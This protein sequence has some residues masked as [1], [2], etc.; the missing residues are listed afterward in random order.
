MHIDL[1]LGTNCMLNMACESTMDVD[2]C[3]IR[4]W[5]NDY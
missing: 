1:N 2:L 3:L 5:H 4:S